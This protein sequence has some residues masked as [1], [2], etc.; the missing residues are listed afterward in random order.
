ME[1][2]YNWHILEPHS[3][4]FLVYDRLDNFNTITTQP[5]SMT[6]SECPNVSRKLSLHLHARSMILRHYTVFTAIMYS[7][8]KQE[9]SVQR[10][11]P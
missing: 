3:L 8:S 11:L 2:E 10:L 1:N 9:N 7:S 4:D 5:T 6:N